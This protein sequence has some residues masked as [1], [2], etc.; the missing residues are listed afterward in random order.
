[1]VDCLDR[2]GLGV[3]CSRCNC[4][5]INIFQMYHGCSECIPRLKQLRISDS[6][7]RLQRFEKPLGV[8]GSQPLAGRGCTDRSA[9]GIIVIVSVRSR[10]HNRSV[11]LPW[12]STE[13]TNMREACGAYVAQFCLVKACTC[14]IG[15]TVAV[16]HG[17]HS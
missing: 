7:A 12:T 13:D 6:T 10:F 4:V 11:V 16:A 5:C 2:H 14:E 17:V 15:A 1:M 8:S 9:C 3:V